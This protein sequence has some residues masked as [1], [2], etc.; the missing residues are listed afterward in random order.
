MKFESRH[1]EFLSRKCI[2]KMSSTKWWPLCLCVVSAW[3]ACLENKVLWIDIDKTSIWRFRVRSMSNW[4]QSKCLLLSGCLLVA[5][6]MDFLCVYSA[7]GPYCLYSWVFRLLF[8][9]IC[10]QSIRADSR[11]APSQWE[12]WLQINAV[13]HWLGASPESALSIIDRIMMHLCC[14]VALYLNMW[15]L[16]AC[17]SPLWL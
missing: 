11:L 1:K 2:L 8:L 10:V 7:S 4:C 12:T 13:S 16:W 9:L 14:I 6:D 5:F 3:P 15:V 17:R